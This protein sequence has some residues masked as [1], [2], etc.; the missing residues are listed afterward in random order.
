M[1]A[2]KTLRAGHSIPVRGG[3]MVSVP[4]F[5][6]VIHPSKDTGGFWGECHVNENGG[7]FTIGRTVK[8]TQSNMYESVT[9]YLKDDYPDI[10]DYSLEF[11][12]GED[13][14]DE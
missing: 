12:M 5:Q 8:E 3:V 2:S 9:L 14:D 4:V 10:T 11:S 1:V 13:L 7:A 6:A